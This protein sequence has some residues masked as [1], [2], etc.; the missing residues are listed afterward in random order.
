MEQKL[1]KIFFQSNKF[2]FEKLY[3]ET[4]KKLKRK[5]IKFII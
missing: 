4:L 5:M 3:I 1:S 2:K